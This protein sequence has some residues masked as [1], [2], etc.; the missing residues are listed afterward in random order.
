MAADMA[1]LK[2]M[3]QCIELYKSNEDKFQKFWKK[4]EKKP[5]ILPEIKLC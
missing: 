3:E 5:K 1:P 2:D 4:N